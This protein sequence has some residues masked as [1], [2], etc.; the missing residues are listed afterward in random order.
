MTALFV[1]TCLSTYSFFKALALGAPRI[2]DGQI[3]YLKG[4]DLFNSLPIFTYIVLAAQAILSATL[5]AKGLYFN[6]KL[7]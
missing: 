7:K 6:G 4:L 5:W 3:V 2:I 1:V